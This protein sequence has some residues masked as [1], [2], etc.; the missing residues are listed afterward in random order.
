MAT[1]IHSSVG[2]SLSATMAPPCDDVVTLAAVD[3]AAAPRLFTTIREEPFVEFVIPERPLA[4]VAVNPA[5]RAFDVLLS[6]AFLVLLSPLMLAGA[7]LVMISGPGPIIFRHSRVGQNGKPF[8]C[9][10]FRTM[11]NEAEDLLPNLLGAC[12]AMRT[13]W[14]RDHKIRRDPRVTPIGQVL[15]RFS[16]DELPQLINVLRGDM[17]IVGPRPIV[18]AEVERYAQNFCYYC[19]VKPGLTGLWQVSGRNRLSYDRRVELDSEYARSKSVTGD[20]LIILRTLPE[21]IRGGG[22]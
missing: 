3:A 22:C 21:V 16:I 12:G 7:L 4:V 17:S 2:P 19:S 10:K 1:N 13:E 20:M 15:R 14:L 11:E 5:H 9:L 18:E 8:V 6:V